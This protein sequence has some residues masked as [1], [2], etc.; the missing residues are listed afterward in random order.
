MATVLK[1]A[2][3]GDAETRFR[4]EDLYDEPIDGLPSD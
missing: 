3:K 2:E 4:L 1:L